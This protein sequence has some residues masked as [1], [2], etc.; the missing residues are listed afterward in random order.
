MWTYFEM[1]CYITRVLHY[2]CV[3]LLV[4]YITRVLHY[5]CVTLLVCYITRE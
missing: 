4:C 5:S 1:V 2:S 3:T